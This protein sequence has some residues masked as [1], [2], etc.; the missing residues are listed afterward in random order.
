MTSFN[1]GVTTF[2]L[3][4]HGSTDWVG[5]GLAGTTAWRRFRRYRPESSSGTCE[6]ARGSADRGDLQQSAAKGNGNGFAAGRAA[7]IAD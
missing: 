2:L 4:R 7:R 5:K 3:I 1:E 6:K